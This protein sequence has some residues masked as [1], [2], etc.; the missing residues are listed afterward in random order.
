MRA[1]KRIHASG[2]AILTLTFLSASGAAQDGQRRAGNLEPLSADELESAQI[3][4]ERGSEEDEDEGQEE[5]LRERIFE[6]PGYFVPTEPASSRDSSSSSNDLSPFQ[7]SFRDA[8]I[9]QMR[10]TATGSR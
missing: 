2:A 7:R 1:L 8:I 4:L 5:W 3:L 6:E 9:D 10:D